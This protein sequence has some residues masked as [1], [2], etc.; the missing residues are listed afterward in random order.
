MNSNPS[1]Y[2][3][4]VILCIA[5]PLFI[6]SVFS[7]KK[8]NES[9]YRDPFIGNYDFYAKAYVI[10]TQDSTFQDTSWYY[11]GAITK[12]DLSTSIY[13]QYFPSLKLFATLQNNGV[14]INGPDSILFGEF[15]GTDKINFTLHTLEFPSLSTKID[16]VTGIKK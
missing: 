9:D 15:T 2:G 13:I 3:I 14:V 12:G 10:T 8:K 16:S 1:K 11:S 5:V 4:S 6:L 7:C